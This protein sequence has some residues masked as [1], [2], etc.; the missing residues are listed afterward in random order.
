MALRRK[1]RPLTLDE[2]KEK[3]SV[4]TKEQWTHCEPLCGY[5]VLVENGKLIPLSPKAENTIFIIFLLDVADY[6]TDR[7]LELLM[8]WQE[9]YRRLPW[10]PILAFRSKYV[11]QKNQRFYE[12]FRHINAFP[13]IPIFIDQQKDWFNYFDCASPSIV[14]YSQGNLIFKSSLGEDFSE[15]VR[16]A[17]VKLQ[18]TLHLNN[19]GL[20]LFAVEKIS[21]DKPIDRSSQLHSDMSLSGYWTL[22]EGSMATDDP[23]A[24]ITIPFSGTHLRLV[25]I[26]HPQAREN[27]KAQIFLDNKPLSPAL[28]GKQ[29]NSG[30]RGQ[31]VFEINK[32]AGIYDLV[33]SDRLIQGT[34]S[35]KLLNALE[36]PLMVYETRTV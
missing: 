36:N 28:H 7:I 22:T 12:R 32:Y 19:P 23:N 24:K 20:P 10:T 33:Q 27:T 21:L 13:T 2:I 15:Q 4:S 3:I 17:E 35:I 30:D 9:R 16:L 1:E 11:F 29:V 8:S 6:A 5:T 18:E 34:I 31:S 26:T 25:S 14:F